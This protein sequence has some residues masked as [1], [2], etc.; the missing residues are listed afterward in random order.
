MNIDL[1]CKD[2]TKNVIINGLIT[3]ILFSSFIYFE[4]FDLTNKLINTITILI[5]YYLFV[6]LDK[7][8]MFFSGFFISIFWFW[9]IGISFIYY[10][11]IYLIPFVVL[12]IGI[13]YGIIFYFMGYFKNIVVRIL[14]LFVFSFIEPFGFNWLKL[15]LPLINTYFNTY[16]SNVSDNNLSI[17]LPKYKVSQ[18]EKWDPK[19]I[20]EILILNFKAINYG[21]KNNYDIVV[22]PETAF[23]LAINLYKS[24]KKELELLSKKIVIITGGL[25]YKN[26]NSY[27]STYI[28]DNGLKQIINKVVLVPFGEYIP[29]PKFIRDILNKIFFNGADDFEHN[30]LATTFEVKNKKFRNAICYEATTDK[31]YKNLDTKYIIA[32]SNNGW[33][34]PSIEP[35]LQKLLLR[36]YAKKYNVMIYH[37]VNQSKSMIIK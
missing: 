17:Y 13:I 10:E 8:S 31:I 34:V 14:L 33:F 25:S 23:P 30:K 35:I 16:K 27:N 22:L 28:F 19:H 3:S 7:K 9:W 26:N 24:I 11:L 15:D 36:Y 4:Y 37:C 20:N 6:T 32:T 21:I 1:K 2:Y 5:S 18:N 29:A 12:F